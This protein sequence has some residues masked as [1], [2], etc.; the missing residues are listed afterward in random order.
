MVILF[1]ILHKLVVVAKKVVLITVVVWIDVC[2]VNNTEK[3]II[4]QS[5]IVVGVVVGEKLLEKVNFLFIQVDE[6][7]VKL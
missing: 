4:V 6:K 3:V 1:S 5:Q 2:I 7:F